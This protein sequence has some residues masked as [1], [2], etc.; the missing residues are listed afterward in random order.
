MSAPPKPRAPR[1]L[2]AFCIFILGLALVLVGGPARAHDFDPGVLALREVA[3]NRFSY[4]FTEPV[5][6]TNPSAKPLS[7]SVR[8]PAGCAAA[9]PI[10][11]CGPKGLEGEIAIEGL[12]PVDV[13]IVVDVTRLS[14]ESEEHV[15]SGRAPRVVVGA[16]RPGGLGAWVG[17]GVEHV[18]TGFDHLAF[19]VALVFLAREKRR[20]L[21]TVTGFTLAH[22]LTLALAVKDVLRLPGPPVEAAIAASVV[23]LAREAMMPPDSPPTLARRYPWAIA[24]GFGL[25]HGLGFA[26]ALRAI[27]LPRTAWLG[28][29]AAFNVGIES[30]QLAVVAVVVAL[31]LVVARFS[32][33]HLARAER[34]LL[35][36]VGGVAMSWFVDR[37]LPIFTSSR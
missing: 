7:V 16:S 28:P 34:W 27:G 23:L 36:A 24:F 17:L 8:F 32:T 4:A 35:V 6:S 13:P 3:P 22:S 12:P 37:A 33:A 9:G 18:L 20:L 11:T 29:L 30:G 15:M 25:V 14:G 5:S 10:V 26:D 21:V 1:A 19:V 31:R 2:R